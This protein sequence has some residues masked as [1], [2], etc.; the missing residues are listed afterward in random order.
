VLRPHH[1]ASPAPLTCCRTHVRRATRGAPAARHTARF[2]VSHCCDIHKSPRPDPTK[3]PT[4]PLTAQGGPAG[5][6]LNL[7]SGRAIAQRVRRARAATWCT[8]PCLADGGVCSART[9]MLRAGRRAAMA[10]AAWGW[11]WGWSR[12]TSTRKGGALRVAAQEIARGVVVG[13]R[14]RNA[15]PFCCWWCWDQAPHWR[16][17][18]ATT[19]AAHP[20]DLCCSISPR[21]QPPPAAP[22]SARLVHLH[23]NRARVARARAARRRRVA[24]EF[25]CR[26]QRAVSHPTAPTMLASRPSSLRCGEL[27]RPAPWASPAVGG[28]SRARLHTHAAA[29]LPYISAI[30]SNGAPQ[31]RCRPHML[32]AGRA[33]MRMPAQA[34]PG[35]RPHAG[36]QQRSS[37]HPRQRRQQQR[38]KVRL[39]NA[40]ETAALSLAL[41]FVCCCGAAIHAS[42]AG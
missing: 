29:P 20:Q 33:C 32:C 39:G 34:A 37:R 9:C 27:E 15:S 24:A 25:S 1:A 5:G 17:G 22:L 10:V 42:Q 31:A 4:A 8:R 14:R 16:P 12:W 6:G 2:R 23:H 26:C 21:L 28:W 40:V 19:T 11:G 35:G 38:R 7:W 13:V 18:P 30:T 41:L 36:G 3:T